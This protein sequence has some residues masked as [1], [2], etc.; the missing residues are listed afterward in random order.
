MKWNTVLLVS[1]LLGLGVVGAT[2]GLGS[3]SPAEQ[4]TYWANGQ[5]QSRSDL[6]DGVPS[7]HCERWHPNG[8]RQAE[9]T[10][11]D[12]RMEGP[13][14]FWLPDGTPDTARSGTYRAGLRVVESGTTG[15]GP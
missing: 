10:L 8:S 5:L 13:W 12:G 1:G 15:G 3:K 2:Q 6:E 7:G 4:T 14:E 9:G 11:R